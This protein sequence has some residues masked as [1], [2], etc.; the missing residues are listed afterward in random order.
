MRFLRRRLFK[1][2]CEKS[3]NQEKNQ[4]SHE[5]LKTGG[6]RPKIKRKSEAGWE[7][8]RKWKIGRT[9]KL[10]KN[11]DVQISPELF[12]DTSRNEKMRINS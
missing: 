6:H 11:C 12:V 2:P 1:K 10:F 9:W 5:N 7:T 3:Q 4:K 8:G